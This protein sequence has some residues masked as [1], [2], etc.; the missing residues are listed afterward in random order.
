MPML[1]FP[2]S[3]ISLLTWRTVAVFAG[4]VLARGLSVLLG[5][6]GMSIG[7][8]RMM[9]GLLVVAGFVMLCCFVVVLRG[10]LMMV[11]CLGMMIGIF[12]GHSLISLDLGWYAQVV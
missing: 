9:S 8:M 5:M 6:S 12:V 2:L 10:M 4:V 1:R 7:D 11:G 3:P